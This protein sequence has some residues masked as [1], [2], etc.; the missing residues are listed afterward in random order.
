MCTSAFERLIRCSVN[1][2]Q[3]RA[4]GVAFLG[5]SDHSGPMTAAVEGLLA[6]VRRARELTTS[7][8]ARDIRRAAGVTQERLALALGVDRTTLARWESGTTRPRPAELAAWV[9]ALDA[10]RQEGV[11]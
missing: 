8:T 1:E 11:R 9:E 7:P 5:A 6:E 2:T 10:L 3:N 4:Q